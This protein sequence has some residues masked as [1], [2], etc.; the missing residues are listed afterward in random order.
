MNFTWRFKNLP[1]DPPVEKQRLALQ[2]LERQCQGLDASGIA[3]LATGT[4]RLFEASPSSSS[5]NLRGFPR[6]F[7]PSSFS[8]SATNHASIVATR[9]LP[10]MKRWHSNAPISVYCRPSHSWF[11]IRLPG[12]LGIP[13]K[14]GDGDRS[15]HVLIFLTARVSN[16]E[17]M[18]WDGGCSATITDEISFLG[19]AADVV[20]R[21]T[22]QATTFESLKSCASTIAE[23]I[24][25]FLRFRSLSLPL[26]SVWLQACADDGLGKFRFATTRKNRQ[27]DVSTEGIP[28]PRTAA[29]DTT[30]PDT[31]SA[32]KVAG[33]HADESEAISDVLESCESTSAESDVI[34]VNAATVTENEHAR[35]DLDNT[36][37][38]GGCQSERTSLSNLISTDDGRDTKR[39]RDKDAKSNTVAVQRG[40]MASATWRNGFGL[41]MPKFIC[42]LTL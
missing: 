26:S 30:R 12:I 13:V 33:D 15:L 23:A 20:I 25:R 17:D 42:K 31:E 10:W 6:L 37:A 19:K 27:L 4:S 36:E 35:T 14:L 2:R 11:G 34:A 16:A 9:E 21:R 38:V 1:K 8:G 29:G 39:T 7:L 5:I 40:F 32:G 3:L 28:T 41:R 24:I 18:P 22:I